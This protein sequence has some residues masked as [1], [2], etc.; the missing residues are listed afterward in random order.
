MS[1]I[2]PFS[3]CNSNE[4]LLVGGKNSS[5]GEL[6]HLSAK[7]GFRVANGFALTTNFYDQY[8]V[9]NHLDQFIKDKLSTINY[10][11]YVSLDLISNEIRYRFDNGQIPE[12]TLQ[13]IENSFNSLIQHEHSVAVRSSAIAEDTVDASFAGQQDTFLNVKT[14]DDLLKAIKNCLGSLF[15]PHVLS[16]RNHNNISYDKVKLSVG[17]QRM[18]R[19]DLASSG[20]AFSIDPETGY[21]GSVI[22]NGNWGLGESVVGGE[23]KPDEF[24][25]DKRLIDISKNNAIL[26]KNLG[27]KQVKTIFIDS[28]SGT[29]SIPTSKEEQ[30]NY[31]LSDEQ[32]TKLAAYILNLEKEY[33]GIYQRPISID[34]EWAIDGHDGQL[35]ILQTRPETVHSNKNDS[36]LTFQQYTINKSTGTQPILEG[37]AIG[38]Q[39]SCGE[40]IVLASVKEAKLFK[41][42]AILVTEMTTPDWE[43]IMRQAGGIITDRGGRTCHA[44]IIARE[45]GVNAIVGTEIASSK[46]LGNEIV[47]LSCSEGPTGKI[48]QGKIAFTVEKV[49]ISPNSVQRFPTNLMLNI[50]NPETAPRASLLPNTGVG[51]VRMEFIINNY[52]GVHPLALLAYDNQILSNQGTLHEI[53]DKVGNLT[54]ANYFISKLTQG[55]TKIASAFYPKP[56]IVRF[57]DFKTNEYRNLLGGTN[58]EPVE[59]N[60]MLGW[61]GCSRYYS[62]SYHKAFGLECIAIQKLREELKLDNIIVMLPFCRTP[63]ECTQVQDVMHKYGLE[64]GKNGLKVYLMCEIPSNVMEPERF[65]PYIDGVSIGGNDLLQLTLGIDRD[66]GLL[67]DLADHTNYSYRKMIRK[68][69]KNYQRYGVKVG[70][71][72]QQPSESSEFAN[73]LMSLDIDSISVTP[74][75]LLH[76]FH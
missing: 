24:E 40:I 75:S 57:S 41:P 47:T 25:I 44:A 67:R 8:I 12:E 70:F 68:A 76:F 11:N 71:C 23:V 17:I 10:D 22:I 46:L 52:I 29:E 61:R 31:C 62:D 2:L 14:F 21:K 1:L 50:G 60:P 43:P 33:S 13:E 16:Y 55:L 37:V 65:S 56:V 72:G 51:L 35:Y 38:E 5:L 3:Q 18:V 69:V 34:V 54:G 36:T 39:I 7:Y 26:S 49:S 28:N 45:L 15:T 73:F 74:D 59:E 4:K 32:A 58:F 64:R 30:D 27:S 6:I 42:G 48:Y 19:A 20:V 53:E 9:H 66:S 63:E